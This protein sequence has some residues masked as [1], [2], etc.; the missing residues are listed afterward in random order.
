MKWYNRDSLSVAKDDEKSLLR[1]L[2][3]QLVEEYI[4][5]LYAS[6]D[7]KSWRHNVDALLSRLRNYER[8]S[9]LRFCRVLMVDSGE[10]SKLAKGEGVTDLDRTVGS[11][12]REAIVR[13]EVDVTG[14]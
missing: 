14:M 13:L 2:T 6:S 12:S 7:E 5:C 10:S 11:G 9:G 8:N 3:T 1:S 4:S